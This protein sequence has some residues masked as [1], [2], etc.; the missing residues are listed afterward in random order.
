MAHDAFVSYSRADKE[1]VDT[2]CKALEEDGLRCWYAPRNVPVGAD[3]D[4]SIM[5]ALAASRAMILVWSKHSDQSRH[6]K[7]EVALALDEMEVTVIPFRI[8]SIEPSKLRY[9]LGG[10]QW[11]DA[12]I[13]PLETNLKRLVEQVKAAMPVTGQLLLSPEEFIER[14]R[15][16]AAE[17]TPEGLLQDRAKSEEVQPP[18]EEQTVTDDD[19]HW[20]REAVAIQEAEAAALERAE[21]ES[22]RHAEAKARLRAEIEALRRAN[23]GNLPQAE[24]ETLKQVR[25]EALKRL[26]TEA[27][28]HAE[29]K[30]R[31]LAEV[32]SLRQAAEG[33]LKR[34][35]AAAHKQN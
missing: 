5:E 32:E 19:G 16:V 11:L 1:T 29:A 4:T 30:A 8:E 7:R 2:I 14:S 22:L 24:A 15:T 35:G 33:S 25:E 23:T 27:V 9:Y 10:I 18:G 21:A 17:A 13:P 12:S 31:L 28:E 3:W 26:E 6:V 34:A 20:L